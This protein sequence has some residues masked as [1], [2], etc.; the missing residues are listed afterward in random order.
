MESKFFGGLR[1]TSPLLSV[2]PTTPCRLSLRSGRLT[3]IKRTLLP[4]ASRP[5]FPQAEKLLISR[6]VLPN[7]VCKGSSRKTSGFSIR[8]CRRV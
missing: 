4:S 6:N 8:S 2:A 7:P 1:R 5:K 3:A